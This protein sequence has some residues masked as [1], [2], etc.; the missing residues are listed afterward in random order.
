MIPPLPEHRRIVGILDQAFAAIATAKAN[1][2]KNLRNARALF[3]S[4][5]QSVFTQRGKGWVETT[6]GDQLTL[7]RGFDI[8]KDQQKEGSVPVVSSGGTKSFHDTAMV[9]APGVV[10]G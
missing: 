7:Q 1:A 4:H 5:L 6:I 9:K 8:T 3:E 10:I 2:E